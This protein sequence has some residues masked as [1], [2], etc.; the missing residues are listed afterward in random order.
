MNN[1]VI[2][3]NKNV[4][5]IIFIH[6]FLD[7]ASFW[8]DVI[9]NL[10][11][12]DLVQTLAIDLPGMGERANDKSNLS[13]LALKDYVLDKIEHLSGPVILVGHSMGSQIAELVAI[14]AKVPIKALILI[15]P[16]P[17]EGNPLPNETKKAMLHLPGNEQA[18]R[19]IRTMLCGQANEKVITRMVAAGMK[20]SSDTLPLL[21]EAWSTGLPACDR[22]SKF[23][24]PVLIIGGKKDPFSTPEMIISLILKRFPGAK[25][26]FDEHSGHWP[27]MESPVDI[28]C[29]I[30]TFL[31]HLIT[32]QKN[33]LSS[34]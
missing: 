12:N 7:E 26:A 32:K 1:Q 27:H 15:S 34:E 5:T 14:N 22:P 20:V 11:E 33:S 10:G 16:V 31:S 4:I 6:G 9:I 29:C 18:H 24:A 23:S 8:D 17:L 13:L 28:A 25:I 2:E 19:D 30:H 3:L 21:L